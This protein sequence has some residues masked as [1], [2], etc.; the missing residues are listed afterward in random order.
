MDD[1]DFVL[2]WLFFVLAGLNASGTAGTTADDAA[3]GGMAATKVE[4][5]GAKAVE[6]ASLEPERLSEFGEFAM[7]SRMPGILPITD[8]CCWWVCLLLK[9]LMVGPR[10]R[11]ITL[12]L[13]LLCRLIR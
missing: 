9:Q 11:A 3:L 12:H 13:I 1:K 5:A 6:L 7:I 10:M 4:L 2:E 8:R